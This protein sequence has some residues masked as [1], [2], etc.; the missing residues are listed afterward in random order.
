MYGSVSAIISSMFLS[1][2]QI[3]GAET[4]LTCWC[5][6]GTRSVP[7]ENITK[8]IVWGKMGVEPQSKETL[9]TLTNDN[10]TL[11]ILV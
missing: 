6:Q 1:H 9:E 8:L 10:S 4:Y 5:Q 3:T 11:G 7:V 2:S